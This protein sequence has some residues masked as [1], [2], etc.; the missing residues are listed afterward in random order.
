MDHAVEIHKNNLDCEG[1]DS[2]KT[3]DFSLPHTSRTVLWPTHVH[4]PPVLAS[5][6]PRLR[7]QADQLVSGFKLGTAVSPLS[8]ICS[9]CGTYYARSPL[10]A[11]TFPSSWEFKTFVRL[12]SKLVISTYQ[13]WSRMLANYQIQPTSKRP[14]FYL[15]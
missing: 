15:S 13:L 3:K 12:M 14:I 2:R 1:F 11:I 6:V 8:Y 9:S 7:L 10:A 4:I 5:V